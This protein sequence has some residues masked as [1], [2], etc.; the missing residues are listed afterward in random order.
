[1]LLLYC[2]LQ[3]LGGSI[4]V[5][6]A[7]ITD[8]A[9]S[10]YST[11][12]NIV[13]LFTLS[14]LILQFPM[15]PLSSIVF[16]KSYYWTMMISFIISAI[17]AWIRYIAEKN[18]FLALL[19]HV[20]IGAINSL[21]LSGCAV[22]AKLWFDEKDRSIPIAIGS[23]SNL[24]GCAYGLVIS[25]Y[26]SSIPSLLLTQSIYTTLACLFNILFSHKALINPC[27]NN[28]SLTYKFE[29]ELLYKDKYLLLLIFF[30]S[31]GLGIAYTLTGI[32]YQLLESSGISEIQAGWIGFS[33]YVGGTFGGLL[34]SVLV[35]KT[36]NYVKPLRFYSILSMI[37]VGTWA[38]VSSDFFSGVVGSAFTGFGLFGIMPLGIEIVIEHNKFIS[39]AITTNL[40]YLI[41]QGLS[42]I[43][44]YPI[45]YCHELLGFSGLWLS[46][47][48]CVFIMIALIL[49]Y[50]TSDIESN[51]E[52]SQSLALN[53]NPN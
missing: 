27:S 45:I 12:A 28:L 25:P 6:Y 30:I 40:V 8:K 4:W 46:L 3:W 36:K 16:R 51:R 35:V 39:E 13:N 10:Y 47:I 1:M 29:L 20:L 22:L 48:L 9:I 49:T 11:N 5:T 38:F 15:A 2:Y 14:F 17:G 18:I 21:T 42:V 43:F 44:T 33:M 23:T 53:L 50:N 19:G 32:I 31:S 52:L 7:S 24:L 41:A 37:G 34:S 26:Y